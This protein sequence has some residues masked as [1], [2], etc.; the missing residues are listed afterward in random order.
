VENGIHLIH[1]VDYDSSWDEWA[2]PKR[3]RHR[4]R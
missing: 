1:Y 2:G 3:I 4:R